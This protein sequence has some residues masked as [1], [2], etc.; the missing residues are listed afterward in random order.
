MYL[1]SGYFS[2]LF[3]KKSTFTADFTN[4]IPFTLKHVLLCTQH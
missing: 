3:K 2:I 1:I 4:T